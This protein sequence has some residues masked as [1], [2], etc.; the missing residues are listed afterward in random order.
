MPRRGRAE[1]PRRGCTGRGLSSQVQQGPAGLRT[2]SLHARGA[3]LAPPGSQFP[4]SVL[5]EGGGEAGLWG[6]GPGLPAQR[7]R[8]QCPGAAGSGTSVTASSEKY[9][10]FLGGR[11]GREALRQEA[12]RRERGEGLVCGGPE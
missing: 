10:T 8:L 9:K 2:H 12:G 4:P 3:W 7:G 11:V 1:G 6:P 5:A